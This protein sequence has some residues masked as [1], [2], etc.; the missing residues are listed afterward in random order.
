MLRLIFSFIGLMGVAYGQPFTKA[1][2]LR[3][4]NGPFRKQWNV[5]HYDITIEPDFNTRTIKGKNTI[6]FYDE[7]TKLMQIDLQS[8]MQIDSAFN[9]EAK[10]SFE[11]EGNVY[12]VMLRDTN[13]FYRLMPDTNS[14]TL[15]FSGSP[16]EAIQ[17][18]WEGG[19]IWTTDS[20]GRPWTTV[21][22]QGLGASV[23]L[24]CKDWQGDEPDMGVNL[25]IITPDSLMGIG[26]GRL[27]SRK[28]IPGKKI[29]YTWKVVNPINAYNINPAIGAY[30]H[31][32]DTL[33]GEKGV[34]DMDYYVLDYHTQIAKKH[35]TE[36]PRTIRAF[37]YWFGPYPFYEDSYKLMEAPF[38]GME[39]QSNIAYGNKFSNGYLGSDLSETGEGLRWD[40]VIVHESGHEWFG[41]SITTED[42]A[43]MWVHEGFTHY[44]EA[45]FTEYYFGK[46]AGYTY[47]R[48]T[49][50]NIE[51]DKPITGNY[52]V[53][54]E[55]SGDMY[56]KAGAM[57]H[58]IRQIMNDDVLFR[59]MLRDMNRNFYHQIVTADTIESFIQHQSKINT[60]KIFEQYLHTTQV[61]ELTWFTKNGALYFMWD[62]C[63]PGFDMP[64]QI[65]FNK[66][67]PFLIYPISGKWTSIPYKGKSLNVSSDFYILK[68]KK[69]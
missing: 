60:A 40:F 52:G 16:K 47:S 51:N 39:H 34:L 7:S 55:G 59:K 49:R 41:N 57:I 10:L 44:S 36:A 54:N 17:P 56:Y 65:V 6:T 23:W 66:K 3:G 64:V 30:N 35:F 11:R 13:A 42:I 61:P 12:F 18:P 69:E 21:A 48:G 67:E 38:L 1:D 22:C 9:G 14:I 15:W 26:N 25:H 27:I 63:V 31:L 4:S 2:T 8:G 33:H 53:N 24:P 29:I 5:L 58:M 68:R 43:D 46:K 50:I 45:L 62:N 28:Q 20:L 32:H 19:W 37:E